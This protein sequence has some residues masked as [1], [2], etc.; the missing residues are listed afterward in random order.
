MTK[1]K[2]QQHAEQPVM[3]YRF[4]AELR[5][6]NYRVRLTDLPDMEEFV[7]LRLKRPC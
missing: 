5:T 1:L 3:V 4:V 7:G 6:P 2:F